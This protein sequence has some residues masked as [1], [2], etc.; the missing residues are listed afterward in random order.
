MP[1]LARPVHRSE[2][3]QWYVRHEGRRVTLNVTGRAN[4]QAAEQAFR[5]LLAGRHPKAQ[6]VPVPSR[7][8]PVE[9]DTPLGRTFGEVCHAFIAAKART[10]APITAQSYRWRANNLTAAV[11]ADTPAGGLTPAG[12]EHAM[13]RDGWSW[14]RPRTSGPGP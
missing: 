3:D 8:V 4:R 11:G 10:T 14:P 7:S 5:D 12:L 9:L 1:R 13:S 6:S 2:P